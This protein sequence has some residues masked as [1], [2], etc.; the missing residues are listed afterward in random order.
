M[1]TCTSPCPRVSGRQPR[2]WPTAGAGL[3]AF[4]WCPH[5]PG[6]QP[7]HGPSARMGFRGLAVSRPFTHRPPLPTSAYCRRRWFPRA[8]EERRPFFP[9][10]LRA[11][12]A[13]CRLSAQTARRA[14]RGFR[15]RHHVREYPWTSVAFFSTTES[16][17]KSV[18]TMD[19]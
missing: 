13:L 15:E 19:W 14:A 8:V 4:L 6:R 10:T 9:L 7:R 12:Q 16:V 18:M 1:Q 17:S 5:M 11:R 2:H 3:N